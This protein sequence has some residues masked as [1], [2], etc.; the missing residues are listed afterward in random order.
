GWVFLEVHN[1]G[2]PIPTDKLPLLFQPMRRATNEVDKVGRSVGLGLYIVDH[3]ARAHGGRVEV[4]ST[5]GEG[6]TFTVRLPRSAPPGGR[7]T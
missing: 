5:E 1:T 4:S 7:P 3:I 2:T 6:T